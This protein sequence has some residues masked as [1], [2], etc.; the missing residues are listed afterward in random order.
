MKQ[1][2][3]HI[4]MYRAMDYIC[5]KLEHPPEALIQF[6]SDANPYVWKDRKAAD[7]ALQADFEESMAEQH[8][9]TEVDEVTAY[10]AVKHF[11]EEQQFLFFE[12][13]ADTESKQNPS[14]TELFSQI[15]LDKWK[16]LYAIV[17]AEEKK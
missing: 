5:D 3:L 8:I 15:S 17:V 1:K 13:F 2:L 10:N 6:L 14:F 9:A 12:G 11:L 7:P 4:V 16:E